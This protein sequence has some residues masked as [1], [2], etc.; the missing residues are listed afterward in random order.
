M[1][2]HNMM[3]VDVELAGILYSIMYRVLTNKYATPDSMLLSM[4]GFSFTETV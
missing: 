1:A 2:L 4:S 3:L